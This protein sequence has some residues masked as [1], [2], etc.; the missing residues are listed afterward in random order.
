[1]GEARVVER[2][3]ARRVLPA[4]VEREPLDGLPVTEALEALEDHHDRDH[5]GRH[6][7]AADAGREQVGKELVGEQRVALAGEQGMDRV[8]PDQRLDEGGRV[9][10]QVGLAGCGSLRHRVCSWRSSRQLLPEES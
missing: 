10:K 9:A 6:R 7:A 8:S 3:A 4:G 1:V 2:Q 5:Q